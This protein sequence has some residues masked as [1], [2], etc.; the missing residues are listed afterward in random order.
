MKSDDE[1]FNE[2]IKWCDREIKYREGLNDILWLWLAVFI[3][4]G[5]LAYFFGTF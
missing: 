4:I 2:F 5:F 1:K 3:G